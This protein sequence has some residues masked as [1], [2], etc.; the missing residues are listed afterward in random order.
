MTKSRRHDRWA[1]LVDDQIN[2]GLRAAEWCRQKSI[3]QK[4]F[5]RWKRI[6]TKE[7]SMGSEALPAGWCQIQAKPAEKVTSLKLVVNM[8]EAQVLTKRWVAY[9]N[10]VR[11][12]SSL[13]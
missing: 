1:R 10:E 8:Y 12:H 3:N 6:L 7:K 5:G 2:S 9:Y 4:T 11:P 13:S